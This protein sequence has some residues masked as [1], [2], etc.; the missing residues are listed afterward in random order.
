MKCEGGSPKFVPHP[1]SPFFARISST[2][3]AG[4]AIQ[5]PQEAYSTVQAKTH[6]F[7][8]TINLIGSQTFCHKQT[9]M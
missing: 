3:P 4:L 9:L 5:K 1:S 8:E 7:M 2:A 6:K